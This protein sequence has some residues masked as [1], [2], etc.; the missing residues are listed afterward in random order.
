MGFLWLPILRYVENFQTR[1]CTAVITPKTHFLLF[2]YKIEFVVTFIWI[3]YVYQFTYLPYYDIVR[4]PIIITSFM[5]RS[6]VISKGHS[7]LLVCLWVIDCTS[8]MLIFC[9]FSIPFWTLKGMVDILKNRG[10]NLMGIAHY[11]IRLV[12]Y[13]WL[14]NETFNQSLNP[15]IR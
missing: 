4:L 7:L 5:V 10:W 6:R 3:L 11:A 9:S 14:F 12:K 13:M 2:S 15:R 8:H 1:L